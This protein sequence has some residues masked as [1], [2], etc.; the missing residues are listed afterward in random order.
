MKVHHIHTLLIDPTPLPANLV[1][2]HSQL[3]F[4]FSENGEW[5][6]MEENISTFSGLIQVIEMSTKKKSW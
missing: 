5:D 3:L 2:Y 1:K 4:G 6:G